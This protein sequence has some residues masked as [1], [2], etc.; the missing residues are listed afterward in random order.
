MQKFNFDERTPQF[1]QSR[2]LRRFLASKEEEQH[3][4][5]SMARGELLHELF[6]RLRT[7]KELQRELKKMRLEGLIAT[8]NESAE[9]EKTIT[10]ALSNPMAADWF[11]GRYR[12]YNE[13]AILDR[14]DSKESRRPDRVMTEGDKAIVVDFKFG[15][16]RKSYREQ[17]KDYM[18]KLRQMGYTQ[19]T[20]YLWYINSNTIETVQ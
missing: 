19:V 10:E 20:G 16:P 11:S 6:S 17:V 12:L 18:A 13:C 14:N 1:R 4:L 15:A 5:D 2:N 3:V 9:I 7:G 8:G